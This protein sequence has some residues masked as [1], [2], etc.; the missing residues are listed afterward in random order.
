MREANVSED[1]GAIR[2]L[3][4]DHP[5]VVLND[6]MICITELKAVAL[7]RADWEVPTT[8]ALGR[9]LRD[10]GFFPVSSKWWRVKGAKHYV[11]TRKSRITED[12]AKE[13]TRKF[14]SDDED[15][16]DVPF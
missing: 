1:V 15:F 14:Y 11:W 6:R 13:I 16:E 10:E 7:L 2:A 5:S 12:E 8:K 9:L 3:M 4:E